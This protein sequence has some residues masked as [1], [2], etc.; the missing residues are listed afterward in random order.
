MA[1]GALSAE[2]NSDSS[3]S[4]SSSDSENDRNDDDDDEVAAEDVEHLDNI[5][6]ASVSNVTIFYLLSTVL[7]PLFI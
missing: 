7:I 2:S 4:D 1:T 3:S 5:L 6:S